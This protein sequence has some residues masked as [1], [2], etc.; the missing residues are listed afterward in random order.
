[1]GIRNSEIWL[2]DDVVQWNINDLS[3]PPA[4]GKNGA[5]LVAA[6]LLALDA[7]V[8]VLQECGWGYGQ[9]SAAAAASSPVGSSLND[10]VRIA[11]G[12]EACAS[13][14]NPR[15]LELGQRLVTA[16]YALHESPVEF[17]TL[18]ATRLPAPS[19]LHQTGLKLAAR[20]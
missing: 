19:P 18:V 15:I 2:F 3:W 13:A 6:Y 10:D 4:S 20:R 17:P 9:V 5:G 7:D 1:M 8:L 11:K 12:K 16:G 14:E